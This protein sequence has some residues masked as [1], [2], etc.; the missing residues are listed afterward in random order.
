MWPRQCFP[1]GITNLLTRTN[2]LA[3]QYQKSASWYL[4]HSKA[5]ISISFGG[6]DLSPYQMCTLTIALRTNGL[7][8][9][10]FQCWKR[11][12]TPNGTWT[13]SLVILPTTSLLLLLTELAMSSV[14]SH[15]HLFPNLSL[16]IFGVGLWGDV[17]ARA[18]L[19]IECLDLGV[20]G[21]LGML[22]LTRAFYHL[23]FIVT[24]GGVRETRAPPPKDNS[25][26]RAGGSLKVKHA[27]FQQ[28][29]S[30]FSWTLTQPRPLLTLKRMELLMTRLSIVCSR[31]SEWIFWTWIL[32]WHWWVSK[33]WAMRY[34]AAL[35]QI[36]SLGIFQV[37]R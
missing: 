18:S 20:G 4:I 29:M 6:Q 12:E 3:N 25:G 14:I 21:F 27:S 19:L 35:L 34:T 26:A 32:P 33:G 23:I 36:G 28:V 5:S 8:L 7:K 24:K 30:S 9:D 16:S 11:Q 15:P 10:A 1:T 37:S 13:H 31:H 17:N 22:T 2:L